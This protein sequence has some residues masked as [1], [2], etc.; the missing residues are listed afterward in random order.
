MILVTILITNYLYLIS[1]YPYAYLSLLVTIL[2][3]IYLYVIS[4]YHY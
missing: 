2:I 4:N 3:S 1:I